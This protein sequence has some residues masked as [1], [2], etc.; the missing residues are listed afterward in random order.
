MKTLA[1]V[2]L[3]TS[4]AGIA[5]AA[6][7]ASPAVAQN[8]L[9]KRPLVL[10]LAFHLQTPNRE[11]KQLDQQSARAVQ[12]PKQMLYAMVKMPVHDVRHFV[13]FQLHQQVLMS[14]LLA[15]ARP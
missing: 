3:L 6:S 11:Q 5:L 7:L 1:S 8:T 14:S 15:Y 13:V 10:S 12:I 4:L 2:R 9:L